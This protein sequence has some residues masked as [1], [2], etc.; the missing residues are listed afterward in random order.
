MNKVPLIY[1]AS[2]YTHKDL[3][4]VEANVRTIRAITAECMLHLG[5]KVA[6]FS[7][8][9][10][11]HEIDQ[12]I[13]RGLEKGETPPDWYEMDLQILARCDAMC[14]VK[15]KGWDTST[16]IKKEL[17]F[18]LENGIP[19]FYASYDIASAIEGIVEV[20]AEEKD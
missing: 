8:V 9:S 7:P 14:I 20:L 12:E 17:N 13:K 5:N 18:C 19:H 2:P 1:L 15:I 16:G 4:R 6:L 10:H 3:E 11:S